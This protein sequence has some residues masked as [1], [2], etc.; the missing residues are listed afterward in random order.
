MVIIEKLFIKN[1]E[2]KL[3][4]EYFQSELSRDKPA[5]LICHPHPQFLGE[6]SA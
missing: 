2:I 3:E 1:K 6:F 4:A 5:I